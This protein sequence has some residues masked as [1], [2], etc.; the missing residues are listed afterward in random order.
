[1]QRRRRRRRSVTFRLDF[2]NLLGQ[3]T[4]ELKPRSVLIFLSHPRKPSLAS[5]K[6]KRMHYS[7]NWRESEG[8]RD[9]QSDCMCECVREREKREREK[10]AWGVGLVDGKKWKVKKRLKKIFISYFSGLHSSAGFFASFI[11]I[12]F[13]FRAGKKISD[14][15]DQEISKDT[16]F[17]RKKSISTLLLRIARLNEALQK[18]S[19][20]WIIKS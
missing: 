7:F 14:G 8:E 9:R 1:M 13:R 3:K 6:I 15:L 10:S 20:E 17:V 16:K 18:I 2:L 5:Q 11:S 4:F 19:L 12:I